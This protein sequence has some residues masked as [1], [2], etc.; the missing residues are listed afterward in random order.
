MI[1]SIPIAGYFS[2][3]IIELA[4]EDIDKL[5]GKVRIVCNPH[6][7]VDDVPFHRA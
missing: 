7:Q 2:S 4:G 1:R 5:K 3:S 6:L